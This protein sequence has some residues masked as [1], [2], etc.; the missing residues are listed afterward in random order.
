MNQTIFKISSGFL[1]RDFP[2][3]NTFSLRLEAQELPFITYEVLLC[4]PN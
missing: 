2:I 1:P 4:N 3:K